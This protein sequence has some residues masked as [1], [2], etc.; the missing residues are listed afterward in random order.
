[1]KFVELGFVIIC[2]CGKVGGGGQRGAYIRTHRRTLMAPSQVP[3][4]K[5]RLELESVAMAVQLLDRVEQWKED[6]N[7]EFSCKVCLQ[8]SV[9]DLVRGR[10]CH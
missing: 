4:T 7:S 6:P 5:P 10:C 8:L 1:M 3:V 9:M 2:L